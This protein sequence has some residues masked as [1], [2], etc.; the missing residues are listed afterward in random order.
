MV[1]QERDKIGIRYWHSFSIK[2][3][4]FQARCLYLIVIG[5]LLSVCILQFINDMILCSL[6]LSFAVA[7]VILMTFHVSFVLFSS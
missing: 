1:L 3:V 2:L 7:A 4:F 5:S 6:A